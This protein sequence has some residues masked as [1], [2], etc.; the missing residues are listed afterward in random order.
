MRRFGVIIT[1]GCLLAACGGDSTATTSQASTTTTSAAPASTTTT[2]SPS[3]T[4][5]TEPATTSTT[6]TTAPTTTGLPFETFGV[7]E[8]DH[9]VIDTGSADHLNVREG[10][11]TEYGIVG[12]L[13]HD[14]TGVR[15]TG[16][17]AED[18][19]E[20]VWMEITHGLDNGWVASWFL[21]PGPC[22]LGSPTTACVID[23]T[24]DD[25]LNVRVGPGVTYAR[26]GSL[27]FDA[28]DVAATGAAADDTNG[29]EWWQIEFRGEMGWVAAWF[30]TPDPCS[31]ST[32]QPCLLPSGP[33]SPGCVN[34]WT[35]PVPG[36]ADWN[37]ALTQ[38]G[39]YG[40]FA[41]TDPPAFVVE[42][43]RYCTG[44]EDANILGP[45][46]TVERWYIEGYSETDPTYAGRWIVRR[47][48][49][50]FG[51]AWVAPAGS[52]GFGS[53]I[54]ETC[55]DPC[56]VGRPLAG[57]WCEPGCIEDPFFMPCTGI[58]PGTWSPGDCS[59]LPPEVLGC[60]SGL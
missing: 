43:M 38:I 32:G 17:A 10:P 14:A 55:V 9:C 6:A 1:V 57:E 53:G 35:T 49:I 29:R 24:C 18:D 59:G 25:R 54:W 44:P 60:L 22:R 2:T 8:T 26:L 46:P 48:G 23:T 12:T 40:A 42:K 31:A 3:T 11:G 27:P 20:R 50:G 51:L 36:S 16:L 7:P 21:T 34:G 56:M 37:D 30:L 58:A 52:T 19:E 13:A 45:R 47:T 28:V 33:P 39:A 4:T 5:T 15:A 41:Q